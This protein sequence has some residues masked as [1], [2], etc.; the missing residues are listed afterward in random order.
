MGGSSS[1][2][3]PSDAK[4]IAAQMQSGPKIKPGPASCINRV[5]E[6]Q[7]HEFRDAFNQ[8]DADKSGYIDADELRKL[9]E[10][11]GQ[12]A[13]DADVAE[14]MR[15]ADGDGSGQID[16][17]EFATLMAHKMD[18]GGKSDD[19]LKAAFRAFDKN[20]DGTISLEEIK[21]LMLAMGEHA[22]EDDIVKLM[23][24]MDVNGDGN[25]DYEEVAEV[26]TKEM[27]ANGY[28]FM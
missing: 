2:R 8:F 1:K 12:S 28:S 25:V 16:F 13:T 20:G 23:Q 21:E 14:M 3:A 7:L 22:S 10:W 17:W 18:E 19:N 5:T 11:V 4:S 24:S 6:V 26:V 27:K 9:C 15:L